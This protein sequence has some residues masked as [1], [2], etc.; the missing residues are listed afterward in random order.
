MHAPN[1]K[2]IVGT[3]MNHDS[4]LIDVVNAGCGTEDIDLLGGGNS[5][6]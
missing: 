2:S 3:L 1:N 5:Y 4:E 6:N